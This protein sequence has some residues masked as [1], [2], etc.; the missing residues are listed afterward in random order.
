MDTLADEIE[1]ADR[2]A[3]PGVRFRWFHG[4][5]DY[6]GMASQTIVSGGVPSMK[7]LE[8]VE[9]NLNAF[10][11]VELREQVIASWAREPEVRTEEEFAQLMADQFPFHFADPLD[12]R[13]AEYLERT[14]DT[15]YSPEMLRASSASAGIPRSPVA[16][17][18]VSSP[19]TRPRLC[20]I[21][22]PWRAVPSAPSPPSD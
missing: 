14:K 21:R 16:P 22:G 6:P 13:I 5:T 7:Y 4:P 9:Q 1:I 19:A 3:V 10:E 18:W 12:P 15:V 17:G 2:P 8:I 11:P 20:R